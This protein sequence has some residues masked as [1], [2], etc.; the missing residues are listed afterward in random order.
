MYQRYRALSWQ[1]RAIYGLLTAA[2]FLFSVYALFYKLGNEPLQDYDEATYAEVTLENQA[3][4]NPS[5]L[6][7]LNQPYFRKPPLLFWMTAATTHVFSDTEFALRF[8][9]ALAGLLAVL[10]VMAICLEAGVGMPFVLL[11]GA[12]LA[13]SATWMEFARDVRFDN[14]VALFIAAAFYTGMRAVRNPRWY[15]AVGIA[16]ALAVLSKSVIVAFAG[17]ALLAYALLELGWSRTFA[18]LKEQWV[19]A[20]AGIFLLIALPWHI[21]ESITYG[22]AFWHSYLGTEVIERASVNLFPGTN[23]PTNA[24]Y[25]GHLAN[26]AA[27]WT[28]VFLAALFALPFMYRRMKQNTPTAVS[29]L[30]ASVITVFSVLAVMFS[31][32]TKAFGYLM[33]LYPFMAVAIALTTAQLWEGT[34]S[35]KG[36]LKTAMRA[37]FA[38]ALLLLVLFAARHT[39]YNALHINP[40]YGWE[41]GQAYEERDV[42]AIIRN[43][44]D[45]TVYTYNYDAIGAILYYSRIP[46]SAMPYVSTWNISRVPVP[47]ALILATSSQAFASAF[48]H[49]HFTSLYSGKFVSLVSVSD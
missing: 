27:P 28:E 1:K 47:N 7:F 19:W 2:I 12:I 44:P 49:E 20:G 6:T 14:L 13:T 34:E 26:Y 23:N 29:A 17:V 37:G 39:R 9:S 5:E 11:G 25:L 36:Y 4:G 31:A 46:D 40:Y 18:L 15:V 42:A 41:I 35:L 24:E 48:P 10:V 16:L 43:V 32:G 38:C 8:P 30:G 22:T 21:Y 33:P 45:A 3:H